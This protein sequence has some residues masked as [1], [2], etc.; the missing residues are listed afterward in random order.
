MVAFE[1]SGE[2][3]EFGVAEAHHDFDR[4]CAAAEHFGR[5]LRP[6]AVDHGLGRFVEGGG[7]EALEMIR[8][9]AG[10]VT[11][12]GEIVPFAG[13]DAGADGVEDFEPLDTGPPALAGHLDGGEGVRTRHDSIL[14]HWALG[15]RVIGDRP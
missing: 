3:T 5:F 15:L 11:E 9:D 2:G 7:E 10:F 1:V 8:G 13:E 4:G 14:G 6:N 12:G